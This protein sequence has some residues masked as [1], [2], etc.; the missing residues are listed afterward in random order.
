MVAPPPLILIVSFLS[1]LALSKF[2]TLFTLALRRAFFHNP[3]LPKAVSAGVPTLAF[4]LV[5]SLRLRCH[6]HTFVAFMTLRR[7]LTPVGSKPLS[8]RCLGEVLPLSSSCVFVTYVLSNSSFGLEFIADD[9][10]LQCCPCLALWSLHFQCVPALLVCVGYLVTLVRVSSIPLPAH[11]GISPNSLPSSLH[12]W[13]SREVNP[14]LHRAL[15]RRLFA[16]VSDL[17]S[18]LV[19]VSS[20]N[21]LPTPCTP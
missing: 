1:Y 12:R 14:R 5:D 19:D 17:H 15:R 10:A 9:P 4:N 16:M 18:V 7:L 11:V 20:D 21:F 6:E 8:P 3:T 2:S 13:L